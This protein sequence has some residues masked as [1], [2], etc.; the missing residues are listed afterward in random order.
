MNFFLHA[1]SED[2][3]MYMYL[4]YG[5]LQ[6][7]LIK[8]KNYDKKKKGNLLMDFHMLRTHLRPEF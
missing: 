3:H 2:I 1:N 4:V 5:V 7:T 8:K 6:R